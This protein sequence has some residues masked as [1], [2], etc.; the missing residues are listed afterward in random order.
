[1]SRKKNLLEAFQ[2]SD[3]PAAPSA[4][5]APSVVPTPAARGL[6]D[7]APSAPRRLALGPQPL[8]A[9]AVIGLVL[10]FVLGFLAGRGSREEVRAED[11]PAPEPTV[12]PR[13]PPAN[14]PR[15]FQE[16]SA[17]PEVPEA[18]APSVGQAPAAGQRLEDS[19]LFDA[20]NQ[21]T[22]VV[23]AYSS[24]NQDLAWATYEHLRDARLPV[25]PPVASRNLVVVLV[26]AAPTAAE[27]E[28]VLVQ[29]KGLERD[30]KKPY[31]DAYPARID[32]LIPRT[33][34]G[35]PQGSDK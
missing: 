3:A 25:F 31:N 13:T 8:V 17:G 19:A 34:T 6:F 10:A 32:T 11:N 35:S 15:A 18:T 21:Q 16:R 33:K 28:R 5:P 2:K 9:L 26:G 23:A 29:V 4:A 20:K 14:Q 30:G 12:A 22:V 1:M 7:D 24:A 27:L